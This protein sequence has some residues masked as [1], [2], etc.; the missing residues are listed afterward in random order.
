LSTRPNNCSPKGVEIRPKFSNNETY[1]QMRNF[2]IL[3]VAQSQKEYLKIYIYTVLADGAE[4]FRLK[5]SKVFI[6]M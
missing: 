5:V 6:F 1:S 4:F 3:G 2:L